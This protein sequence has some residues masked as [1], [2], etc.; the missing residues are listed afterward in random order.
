MGMVAA[1]VKVPHG[2]PLRALTTTRATTASRMI[3]MS[4]TV[5]SAANPPTL[6]ISSRAICPR[7]L[8]SRRIEANRITK[9]CTAPP[10]TAPMMI[11]RVPGR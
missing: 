7:D 9:S 4:S 11:H 8:P 5:M 1:M 2:L 10:S 6:P 3:M